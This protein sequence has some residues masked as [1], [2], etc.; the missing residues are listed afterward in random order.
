MIAS[1]PVEHR[2]RRTLLELLDLDT[3][4]KLLKITHKKSFAAGEQVFS[5]GA[6]P[7]AIY[8]VVK[9]Q[10]KVARTTPDGHEIILCMPG[11]GDSFCPVTILDGGPQLGMAQ[12]VTDTE[13]LRVDSRQFLSLCLEHPQL[14]ASVQQA[15]LG[16]VRRL[17]QRMELLSFRT[18]R[19]RLSTVLRH[20]IRRQRSVP[21]QP[22]EIRIT[23]QELAQL[24]GGSRESTS[25]LLAMWQREGI[26]SLGR[27]RIIILDPDRLES[28][29]HE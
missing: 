1:K 27:G 19:Q 29:S 8:F 16:E 18:L 22:A 11:P 15:C 23:Q 9:G 12:A 28:L 7:S 10:V 6:P 20:T 4:E 17:V 3:R 21:C 13:V 25:R 24:A 14:Q 5:Q 26:V 2:E